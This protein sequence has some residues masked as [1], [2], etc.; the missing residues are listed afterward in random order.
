MIQFIDANSAANSATITIPT[1]QV[2]DLIIIC[3][4]NTLN[5]TAITL[6]FPFTQYGAVAATA[7]SFRCGFLFAVSS[8]DTSGSWT[9]ATGLSC[10]VFRGAELAANN[11]TESDSSVTTITYPS[12]IVKADTEWILAFSTIQSIDTALE[13]PPSG[14]T[15]AAG[16]VG[17]TA[18]SASFYSNTVKAG[19]MPNLVVSAGGTA[20]VWLA[21]TMRILR[22]KNTNQ[23]YMGIQAADG[24]SVGEKIR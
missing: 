12:I 15:F 4:I 10:L 16:N 19:V 7:C 24:I 2:G 6:P 5:N 20:G 13:T 8:S 18:E 23:N 3:G 22:A 17:A 14:F 9:N 1:H 21:Y 11:N